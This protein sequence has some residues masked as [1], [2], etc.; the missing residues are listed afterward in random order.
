M[1]MAERNQWRSA[2]EMIREGRCRSGDPHHLP[3]LHALGTD[4][5]APRLVVHQD[6]SSLQVRQP[7]A[8]RARTSQ[9]PGAAMNVPDIL[10]ILRALFAD[11]ASLSQSWHLLSAGLA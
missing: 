9:L 8:F 7:P 1:H 10:P 5:H 3:R 2:M 11:M 4:P 6:L